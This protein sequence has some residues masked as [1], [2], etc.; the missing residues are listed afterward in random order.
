MLLTVSVYRQ[1]FIATYK[2]SVAKQESIR[3]KKY[4][5]KA[6]HPTKDDKTSPLVTIP[7]VEAPLKVGPSVAV[8]HAAT[9]VGR[10][11]V[12]S[13]I[14]HPVITGTH[15]RTSAHIGTHRHTTFAATIE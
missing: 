5:Y 8:D 9:D 12:K 6:L 3:D 11:T 4:K 2:R 7:N 10:A 13:L 1:K 15:R 14:P